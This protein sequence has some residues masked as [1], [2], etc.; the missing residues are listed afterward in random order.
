MDSK[1]INKNLKEEIIKKKIKITAP[2]P[3]LPNI[4][5]SLET[6]VNEPKANKPIIINPTKAHKDLR[7]C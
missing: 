1:P 3:L 4:S 2:H 6:K 7:A 5:T